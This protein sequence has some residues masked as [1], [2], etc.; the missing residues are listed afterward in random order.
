MEHEGVNGENDDSGASG[1]GSGESSTQV[2]SGS[3]QSVMGPPPPRGHQTVYAHSQPHGQPPLQLH[4]THH[5]HHPFQQQQQPPPPLP[6]V[7]QQYVPQPVPPQPLG[8]LESAKHVASIVDSLDFVGWNGE[9]YVIVRGTPHIVKT[10]LVTNVDNTTT[11]GGVVRK[12]D[13]GVE[14]GGI[15]GPSRTSASASPILRTDISRSSPSTN[16]NTNT[17]TN[18]NT[19]ANANTTGGGASTTPA[20][21]TPQPQQ[22]QPQPQPL[23]QQQEQ[24]QQQQIIS[25]T[26]ELKE[27]PSRRRLDCGKG[28]DL[29]SDDAVWLERKDVPMD[30]DMPVGSAET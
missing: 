14:A 13:A 28:V 21:P 25:S 12:V 30:Y 4:G 23:P 29:G 1:N 11:L 20:P 2:G 8:T 26:V 16:A 6:P 7:Q 22:L 9:L 18:A 24:Q 5:H 3:Q 15:I 17:T 10:G 27:L 19:N